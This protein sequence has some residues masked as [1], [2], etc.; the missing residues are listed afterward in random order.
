MM[1]KLDPML[2]NL[3]QTTAQLEER[4]IRSVIEELIATNCPDM[5]RA[6]TNR[7]K[8]RE[9]ECISALEVAGGYSE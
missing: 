1:L 7:A 9:H 8:N 2:R 5:I 6:A 3:V 4:T